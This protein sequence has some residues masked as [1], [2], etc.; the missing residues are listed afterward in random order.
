MERGLPTQC[1]GLEPSN[2]GSESAAVDSKV[3]PRLVGLAVLACGCAVACCSLSASAWGPAGGLN[4]RYHG[5][6]RHRAQARPNG[7]S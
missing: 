6:V 7:S 2:K 5:T 3:L 4:L 1:A